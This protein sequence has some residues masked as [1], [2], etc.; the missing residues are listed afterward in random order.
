MKNI[1]VWLSA[2]LA[3]FSMV[4][5]GGG[6]GSGTTGTSPV[7]TA[8]ITGSA[9][10]GPIDGAEIHLY[11]FDANGDAVE[12]AAA[13]APVLTDADGAF[14]F[15]VQGRDLMGISS[16]LLIRTAGG[17]MYGT[18]APVLEAVI[19]DPL[20]L[21][22]AQVSIDCHLSV[23][24][25]VA[26][27]LLKRLAASTGLPPDIEDASQIMARVERQLNVNLAADPADSGKTLAMF[28][29]SMDQV[30]DLIDTPANNPAV[31][32]FIEYLVANLSSSSEILDTR[33]DDPSNTGSD[34]PTA[35]TPFGTVLSTVV[36]T[37][38]NFLILRLESDME[39]IE[40][41]GSD[42]AGITVTLT[43][44]QGRPAAA[45]DE[46]LLG[47]WS[48]AGS[49][50][51]QGFDYGSGQSQAD[52]VSH[53]AGENVIRVEYE[54]AN[55][56]TI[57]EE[58]TVE[59]VDL[60][61]DSDGDGFADGEEHLGWEIIVDTLGYGSDGAGQLLIQR[62]V[63]SDPTL[64]D[65]D[66]DGVDDYTEYLAGTDPRM[67][68]T[69][70]D[71]LTDSEEL[72]RWHSSPIGVDTDGDARGP[73]HNLVPVSD[74]FDGNEL[75]LLSTSPTLADTDADGWSDYEEYDHPTRSPLVADLPR[76]E[77][78]IVDAVDVR[79]DVT[80]AE[81][82]GSSFE[83]GSEL[84]NSTTAT[85]STYNENSINLGVEIGYQFKIGLFPRGSVS[86]KMS[87]DYGHKWSTTQTSANTAQQSHSQYTT[88][89]RTRT[90]TAAT[91]SMSAGIRLRN[92][93]D[94]SYTL[95]KVG[96]TVRHWELDWDADLGQMVKSFQTVATLVPSLGSGFT[97]A[98]GEETP[99]L[100]VAAT[101]LNTD[102]VKELLRRP[103]SLY[104][105]TAYFELENAEHLNFDYLTEINATQT[106]G[107]IIDKGQSDAVEYRVATNVQRDFDG[108]YSGITLG[109]ILVNFLDIDYTTVPRQYVEPASPTN[110]QVLFSL[111][112]LETDPED[113]DSGFWVVVHESE[114]PVSGIYDFGEVPV[115]AG[116][117]VLLIYVR[118]DDG[119]G[120]NALEEQHYG[121]F[122]AGVADE[123]DTDGDGLTDY[124]EV[125]EG[126]QV[127]WTD[128]STTQHI[129]RVLSDPTS[130]DQDGDGVT[131]SDEKAKGTD[132]SN[133]DTDRD[134]IPDGVDVH[135]LYQAQLVYVDKD[136]SGIEDGTSWV[137]A[138]TDLQDALAKAQNGYE[139][140]GIDDDDVAEIWVADGVYKP[141]LVDEQYAYAFFDL[142]S[143]VGVYG[144]F[145]GNDDVFGGET[146][147]SQREQDPR[148]N[149]TILSGDL[150]IADYFSDNSYVVVVSQGPRTLL[151]G[152]LITGGNAVPFSINY[153]THI[154]GGMFINNG[155]TI[156]RNLFFVDNQGVNGGALYVSASGDPQLGGVKVI[157]C[158]FSG[159]MVPS[160]DVTYGGGGGMYAWENTIVTIDGCRFIGNS[161]VTGGSGGALYTRADSMTIKNTDFQYN[162]AAT[163]QSNTTNG[164]AVNAYMC[165]NLIIDNCRF[166]GNRANYRGGA[167]AISGFSRIT[168]AR[169]TN[170]LFWQNEAVGTSST[171]SGGGI[172]TEQTRLSVINCTLAENRS[173]VHGPYGGG[174][175]VYSMP[176]L[177]S[178]IIENSIL[179]GNIT[180]AT[181][182]PEEQVGVLSGD[183]NDRVINASCVQGIEDIHL[184]PRFGLDCI[185]DD[186]KFKETS[187]TL[188]L[189]SGSPCIDTGNTFADA[190]P[191]TPGYQ[192]LSE[193]DLAGDP[194]IVDGDSDGI[195]DVD[196]GA[197]EYQGD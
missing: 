181:F 193:T 137:N 21:T 112:G 31:D 114:H 97:L 56:N 87:F 130:E 176:Y 104:L 22:F 41:D 57:I 44:A 26:A 3:V 194:R 163:V 20:P 63:T 11:Y 38:S 166:I 49:M 89:S 151:D 154:A 50:T 81:E 45:I 124:E 118:D 167:V 195:T 101:G 143:D 159:N 24:S 2:L 140:E 156:L 127:A 174:V 75:F 30:L 108:T 150:G 153:N 73:D 157:D 85:T 18:A 6:G 133:P 145:R 160:Y 71:G 9:V 90:E 120:L 138:F 54:L 152:F 178:L 116:D 169:V 23:P 171:S 170:S 126:W 141:K 144:G 149:G 183:W 34:V 64:A 35:F 69:D 168:K 115:R 131:D 5:C 95:S 67:M 177:D 94:I 102:R 70:G 91:G 125:R 29:E 88:D 32:E 48:G 33:M 15:A 147:R 197:Y 52:L 7:T 86:A 134:G 113:P 106:A 12:I 46:A 191:L 84:M 62:L 123:G 59:A 93:S 60:V 161:T 119:D 179:W 1:I 172:F 79:L 103:D 17:T 107:I 135:P 53:T 136:A 121:T 132:P 185:W 100:Q 68:D 4:S 13:N 188:S 110:E 14:T 187:G 165:E 36:G 129:Y 65:T 158:I 148:V 155:P 27:G 58:I 19:A 186:P 164:G 74:L 25:S 139:S 196:M 39:F 80:Y 92:P 37:P 105:E 162:D 72:N 51:F 76:L 83:Y 142:V 128:S 40:N 28:N 98:P 66:G 55:G 43:D 77:L 189:D 146:K 117:R 10:K 111:Q 61:I 180:G 175:C 190:D 82:T 42:V 184:Y 192:A 8:S 182:A 16:S 47:L 122:A 173:Y 109:E 96:I 78:E 99:V